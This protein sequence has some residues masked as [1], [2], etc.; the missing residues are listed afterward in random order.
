MGDEITTAR[1]ACP[2]C[3]SSLLRP[4]EMASA[5]PVGGMSDEELRAHWHGFFQG[6]AFFP[7]RRCAPCGQLYCPDYFSPESLAS[8]Y[9]DMPDNTAGQDVH[10]LRRTQARYA[11]IVRR[12]GFPPGDY[13][14]VGPDIGLFAQSLLEGDGSRRLHLFEPNLAVW[15]QLRAALGADRCHLSGEMEDYSQVPPSSVAV[16]VMVHVLDHILEPLDVARRLSRLLVPGGL[17]AV[18]THDESSLMATALRSR[19]PAYCLQHPQLYR[20]AS[21]GALLHQAGLRVEGTVKTVNEFP[22]GYLAEHGLAAFG[23]PHAWVGGLRGPALPLRLGN[24][25]TLARRMA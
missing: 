18:V 23:L 21:A 16:A 19:W 24:F 9:A 1:R 5:P 20:P 13:L 25:M 15:P 3:G 14:E 7:Y 10:M 22:V 11:A 2:T 8:L 12:A 17:L 4:G 6:Q